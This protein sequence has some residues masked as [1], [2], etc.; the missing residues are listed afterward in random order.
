MSDEEY[1]FEYSD[2]EEEE[3]DVDIENQYY[4]AKTLAE[5]NP[6][7]A[8]EA[9]E[10][11]IGM[12]E[13]KGEWSFKSLKQI[14]KILFKQQ[15]YQDMMRR[16]DEF[17]ATMDTV[18]RNFS[19]SSI[20]SVLDFV[21]MSQDMDIL[22]QFY[23]RTLEA[24]K[25]A[26]N[27]RLWFKTNLKLGKLYYDKEE[28][29]KLQKILKD[30]HQSCLD[31]DGLDDQKKGTQLLEV[32]ALDIQMCTTTKNHKKLRDL[33]ERSLKIKSAIPHPRIMAVIRE[34]GGKMHMGQ[35][36]FDQAS[37]DFFEAFKNYDEAGSQRRIQC[38]KYLVLANM[39]RESEINPFDSQEAKPYKN[40]HEIVA[41]TN[42]VSAFL[43]GEINEFEKIL[44]ANKSIMDDPFIR[45]YMED[46]L[47]NIRTQVLI[48]LVAPY[49]EIRTEFLSK[50]LNISLT[51]VEALLVSVILDGKIK[52]KIDQVNHKL[53]LDRKSYTS[54]RFESL[55]KWTKQVAELHEA[56]LKAF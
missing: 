54:E 55:E 44:S 37:T 24:L 50:K 27:E 45:H 41:M 46:L 31:T 23:E 12:E 32:Y 16:Y 26:K 1:D 6:D 49:T 39:L 34:C 20:N 10:G 36:E 30:L 56:V 7:K 17:L 48:K 18:T 40:D 2:E 5:T 43:R 25:Q 4:T 13:Q 19:E 33:Y 21:S 28:F 52:G 3:E 47:K 11:V 35:R 14:V 8:L 51:E 22:Q 53:I 38:L 9:F 29:G 42:L 15:K